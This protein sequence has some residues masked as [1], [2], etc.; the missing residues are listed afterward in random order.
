MGMLYRHGKEDVFKCF[1][2]RHLMCSS[3]LFQAEADATGAEPAEAEVPYELQGFVP[4]D[5]SAVKDVMDIGEGALA[6]GVDGWTW[7]YTRR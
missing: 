5:V 6:K 3:R 7:W 2:G 1:Q 4:L